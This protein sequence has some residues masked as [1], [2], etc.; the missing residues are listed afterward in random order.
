MSLPPGGTFLDDDRSFAEG[1]IEALAASG[2]IQGCA[3]QLYCPERV[4]TRAEAAAL[5]V[6]AFGPSPE[7][8]IS[9][10]DVPADSWYAESVGLLAGAGI[11]RGHEDGTFRPLD[12]LT[13]AQMAFLLTRVLGEQE[14]QV[15][16]SRFDDVPVTASHAWA[17][18]RLAA[19][20][21]TVGC[22]VAPARFCPDDPVSRDQMAVFLTRALG[23]EPRV[24]PER[25][26]PL[27]GLPI[28]G[29]DWNRRVMAVKIDDARGA[30]PQ[31]GIEQADAVIETLVEGGLTR[32]IALFH[33]S[34]TASLGPVRSIR[35]T[36][37]GMVLPLGAT[38]AA[39]GGQPWIIDQAVAAGVKVIRE[40]D[41]PPPGMFRI[42]DR[43]AP[44]NLYSDTVALRSRADALGYPDSPPAAMFEWGQLPA[45]IPSTRI[46]LQWSDPIRI[47]WTW[48]G[49]RYRRW[50]SGAPAQWAGPDS[51]TGQ[52]S[53]DTLVLIIAPLSELAPPAGVSGSNVPVLDTLGSGTA[54]V[55]A[56][57]QAVRGRWE[58]EDQRD[59][60]T[61]TTA[62]GA[63]LSIPPGMPWINVFPEGQ[64]I[65]S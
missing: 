27:N 52:I 59:P 3:R 34:D 19:Q 54:F 20:G 31:S 35:P 7:G 29:L 60:F 53:A 58:R 36:D 11:V 55:F 28:D 50:R 22:S 40:R 21:I 63:A 24:P 43:I 5:L 18:E 56:Q 15:E 2:V 46:E 6:R 23:M 41:A 26:A 57:G 61:L 49:S 25:L 17:V 48:D 9:F 1:S 12:P 37:I 42:S 30:R 10:P 14:G 51:S 64:P 39:S 38:V 44:Y 16:S 65:R 33:Q 4:L 62:D 32:W 13:R 45:S 47:T 8:T